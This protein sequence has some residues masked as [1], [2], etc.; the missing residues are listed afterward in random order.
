MLQGESFRYGR[1]QTRGRGIGDYYD[2]QIFA[3]DSHIKLIDKLVDEYDIDI[4]VNSYKLNDKDDDSLYKIYSNKTNNFILNLH[5]KLFKKEEYLL[6]NTYDNIKNLINKYEYK[7][8]FICRIDMYLKDLM[9]N[10]FKEY[11]SRNKIIFPHIDSNLNSARY[12]HGVYHPTIIIPNIYFDIINLNIIYNHRHDI[13]KPIIDRYSID[14]ID[15]M[16]YTLH[17]CSTDLGWN[18]LYIQVGRDY[19][20]CYTKCDPFHSTIEYYYDIKNNIFVK[21]INK[22]INYW[23]SNKDNIE[24]NFQKIL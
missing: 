5:D 11:L 23:N 4:L 17:I 19:N 15:Y 12:Y 21:D 7:F 9:I 6:N 24:F 22:S 8:I 20:T 10:N 14:I 3:S 18:P 1:P 16:I 2:R 13:I